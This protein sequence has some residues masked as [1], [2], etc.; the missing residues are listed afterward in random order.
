MN[1]MIKRMT[2][3][4]LARMTQDEFS[5]V[6][7][8]FEKRFDKIDGDMVEVKSALKTVLDVVLEIPSKK[9]FER[10]ENKV[11]RMDIEL[12]AVQRKVK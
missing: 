6:N 1:N 5:R 4:N 2:I 11:D 3:D 9:A 8:K 12:V 10:L 7:E